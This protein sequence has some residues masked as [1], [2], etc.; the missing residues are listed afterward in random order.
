M[1]LIFPDVFLCILFRLSEPEF[2]KAV[3]STNPT[4]IAELLTIEAI[5][6]LGPDYI[7]VNSIYAFFHINQIFGRQS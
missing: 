2:A 7:Q 4:R 5:R 3:R 1:Q 6:A